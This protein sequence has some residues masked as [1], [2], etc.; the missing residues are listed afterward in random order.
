MT[1][2]FIQF[3]IIFPFLYSLILFGTNGYETILVFTTIFL[4]SETHFGAT[5]PILFY[6]FKHKEFLSE[7]VQAIAGSLFII[8]SASICFFLF[9]NTFYLVFFIF[10]L[11]HVTKQS[12]G[13]CKL[14]NENKKELQFQN[15]YI[16]SVN[17]IYLFLAFLNFNISSVEIKILH[18]IGFILLIFFLL[19]SLI[20]YYFFKN[21]VNIFTTLSGILIFLP[22]CFVD[23]PIHAILLGVTMHYSQYILLTFKVYIS[24]K[25]KTYSLRNR[26]SLN[27]FKNNFIASILIYSSF[28]TIFSLFGQSTFNILNNLI[29][30]PLIAQLL[31]FYLDGFIWKFRNKYN[32]IHTLKHLYEKLL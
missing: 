1:F 16:Y 27:L 2:F 25:N 10:N 28:M 7:N 32:R 9:R 8:I 14:F 11:F 23:K 24:R 13:I 29:I 30:I 17:I 5:W 3:P 26:I 19:I 4:L 18:N 21:I 31:H 12:F 15:I 6:S 22:V 20:Q